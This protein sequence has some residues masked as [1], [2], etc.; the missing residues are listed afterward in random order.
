MKQF[1]IIENVPIS[2]CVLLEKNARFMTQET[3]NQLVDNIKRD[4]Q[5]SSVPF[6][7]PKGDKYEV[8]S[9]NH[10][11][12]AGKMAGL[13]TITIMLAENLSNDEIRAIQLSHN[14]IHGQDDLQ[15]LRELM[16]EITDVGLKEYAGIDESIFSEL[17]KFDYDIVQPTNDIVFMNFT[18]FDSDYDDLENLMK[19]IEENG[20][21]E[22]N[23]LIP[24]ENYDMFNKTVSAI[25]NKYKL[26]AY[27]LT[28]VK[29]MQLATKQ[30]EYEQSVK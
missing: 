18:F 27:G 5:L 10:R 30:L 24:K 7:V 15:L 20:N 8:I 14:S 3:F 12:Q 6:C 26:K 28:I 22:N 13:T 21:I 17:E 2:N 1:K 19:E 9:G 25:Q 23:V 29:M 4:G 16:N 11:V